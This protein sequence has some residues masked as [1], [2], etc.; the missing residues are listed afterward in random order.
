MTYSMVPRVVSLARRHTQRLVE[1]TGW[2]GEVDVAVLVVSELVTNAVRYA[3]APGRVLTLRLRVLECGGLVVDVSDPLPDFPCFD[4]D[5]TC[6]DDEGGRGLPL[7]RL[8]AEL[9]WCPAPDGG[10]KTVRACLPPPLG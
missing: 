1:R 4:G 5:T 7:V 10:G 3:R 6:T 2:K 8:V 9:S